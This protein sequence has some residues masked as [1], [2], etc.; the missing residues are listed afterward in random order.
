MT[1]KKYTIK[2][3]FLFTLNYIKNFMF[4]I[5]PLTA[6]LIYVGT[7]VVKDTEVYKRVHAVVEWYEE[8]SNSYAV[9]LRV[10]KSTNE[11]T[12]KVKYKTVYKAT[13]GEVY[14]AI[15][16]KEFGYW[17]YRD[18]DGKAMECH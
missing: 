8:R 13:D 9:G 1:D 14:K 16:S 5:T 6:I 15:Y 17:F 11:F 7:L 12:G 10:V 18:E 4:I 2:D 3:R